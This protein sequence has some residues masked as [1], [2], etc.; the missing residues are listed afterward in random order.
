[1]TPNTNRIAMKK[2]LTPLAIGASYLLAIGCADLAENP[3]SGITNSYYA[4]PSGFDAAVSASY[5]PLRDWYG[6]EMGMTMTT[7]GTDEF[8]NGSDGS[9]KFFNTYDTQ[10]NGDNQYSRDPHG[11]KPSD[12]AQPPGS[13]GSQMKLPSPCQCVLVVESLPG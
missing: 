8:T 5:T 13:Y 2:L 11:G 3:I 4:T 6:Q 12:V 9:F 1:M 7:F 10:L